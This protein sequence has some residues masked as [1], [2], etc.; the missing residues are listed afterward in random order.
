MKQEN[1]EYLGSGFLLG[2][3]ATIM[4]IGLIGFLS[5]LDDPIDLMHPNHTL[6]SPEFT[7]EIKTIHDAD[8]ITTYK[9]RHLK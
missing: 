6:N 5:Q 3:I 1:K 7:I 8:T 4:F 9:F 2:I